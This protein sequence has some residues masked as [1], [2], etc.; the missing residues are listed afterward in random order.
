[1]AVTIRQDR[2]F[3]MSEQSHFRLRVAGLA[4]ILV[5]EFGPKL[6]SQANQAWAPATSGARVASVISPR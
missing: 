1:M 6:W 4:L 2:V 3:F 5:A